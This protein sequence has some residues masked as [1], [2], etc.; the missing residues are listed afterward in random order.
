MR[1]SMSVALVA[2]MELG[3]LLW[4]RD[5]LTLNIIMLVWPLDAIRQWQASA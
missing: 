1:V 5:N 3:M 2:V 4:V